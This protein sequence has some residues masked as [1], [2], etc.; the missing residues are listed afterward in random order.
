[1]RRTVFGLLLV[2]ASA[3]AATAQRTT[4]APLA[5]QLPLGARAASLGGTNMASRDA[6]SALGNPALA[7]TGSASAFTLGRY[8]G[9]THGGVIGMTTPVGFMGVGVAVSYLDYES[10]GTGA[11]F[12]REEVLVSR[13]AGH[14]SSM[15]AAFSLSAPYKGWRW[16]AAVTYLEE[17]LFSERASVAA[18]TLGASRDNVWRGMTLGI[19]LQNVGPS[20]RGSD[21]TFSREATANGEADID[22][23]LRLAAGMSSFFVPMGAWFD[24]GV[25]GGAAVRRDGLV[26]GNLGGELSWNPIEGI[27]VGLR[28]GVRRPELSVQRPVTAGLGLTVDRFVVDYAWEQMRDGGG[29]HRVGLR[30]R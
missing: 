11:P 19:G 7:G 5:A 23:P 15:A 24:L 14:G 8:H 9:G 27:A 10:V 1:M 12:Y 30:V 29:V 3:T 25:S 2:A 13:G 22:L 6:E 20:M 16:G 4:Y 26:S 28:T 18:L 21:V 17:R